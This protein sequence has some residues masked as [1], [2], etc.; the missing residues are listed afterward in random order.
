[1]KRSILVAAIV[2]GALVVGCLIYRSLPPTPAGRQAVEQLVSAD[3]FSLGPVGAGGVIPEREDLFFT[4][5][6]SRHSSDLFRDLFDR[7]TPEAQLY[8]L[9]GL[10]L[11]HRASFDAYSSRFLAETS[12]VAT[13][14]G[15]ICRD[16]MRTEA[17][18]ALRSGVVEGYLKIRKEF[19]HRP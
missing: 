10:R 4:I 11:T 5:L 8:A 2:L 18:T 17:V 3:T 19:I 13:M 14:G 7:G 1:M 6:S 15:C 12:T 16:S 9:C